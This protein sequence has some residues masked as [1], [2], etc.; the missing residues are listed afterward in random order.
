M[1]A[2]ETATQ[3]TGAVTGDGGESPGGGTQRVEI[4]VQGSLDHSWA[5]W[6]DGLACEPA[7]GGKTVLR[8]VFRDQAALYGVLARVRD[9]GLSLLG[10]A[11]NPDTSVVMRDERSR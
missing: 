3:R 5:D 1:G 11:I 8:G 6:F 7:A 10:L 2:A 4:V 9:L